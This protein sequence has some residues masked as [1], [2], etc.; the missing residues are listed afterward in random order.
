MIYDPLCVH[1]ALE[2]FIT[3]N[4]T[5]RFYIY[6]RDLFNNDIP[7][8]GSTFTVVLQGLSYATRSSRC[9]CGDARRDIGSLPPSILNDC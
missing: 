3:A 5:T 8:G 1:S 6:A 7:F 2:R 9:L 4:F